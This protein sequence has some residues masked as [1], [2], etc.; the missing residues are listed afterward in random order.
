MFLIEQIKSAHSKVKS[1]ADF[2]G[3]IQELKKLGVQ[4]YQ[5]FVSDGHTDY[6]GDKD[7]KISSQ[8]MYEWLSI[9]ELSDATHFF[10][11]L[12]AHQQGNTSYSVFCND[13]A[14]SGIEKWEVSIPEMTCTYFDIAGNIVLTE[15]IPQ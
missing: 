3:Y 11:R 9:N 5:T 4:Y 13:C 2:P 12:K 6:Y 7:Y 8:A 10:A 14:G 15:N 1:G